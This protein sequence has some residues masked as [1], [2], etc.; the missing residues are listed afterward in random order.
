MDQKLWGKKC[1]FGN[2]GAIFDPFDPRG[3]KN[4]IFLVPKVVDLCVYQCCLTFWKVPEKSNGWVKSYGAKT[5]IFVIFEV[6]STPL[7]PWSSKI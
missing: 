5:A 3:S 4:R 1:N 7:T 2:F 6:F